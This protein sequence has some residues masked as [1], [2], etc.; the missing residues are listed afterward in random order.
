MQARP[1]AGGT[2]AAAAAGPGALHLQ[3][4]EAAPQ[5]A[6]QPGR[7]APAAPARERAPRS[8]PAGGGGAA[9]VQPFRR[10]LIALHAGCIGTK[11]SSR[12][13]SEAPTNEALAHML[14]EGRTPGLA[15]L[16]GGRLAR[17]RFRFRVRWW[18]Q[19]HAAPRRGAFPLQHASLMLTPRHGGGYAACLA[20]GAP[21]LPSDPAF[22]RDVTAA[23]AAAAAGGGG[24]TVPFDGEGAARPWEELHM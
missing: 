11:R 21:A 19:Q 2:P 14:A 3:S 9:L 12:L 13:L 7:A 1:P 10:A 16:P 8:G 22:S 17:Y 18:Q 6:A 24:L 23:V 15:A 5:Q 20:R 4:L